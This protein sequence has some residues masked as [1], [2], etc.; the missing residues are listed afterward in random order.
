M[1]HFKEIICPNCGHQFV[2][3][4]YAEKGS[5]F[6][7]YCRKGMD[8]ELLSTSCPNCK[9]EM[10]ILNDSHVGVDIRSESIDVAGTVRGL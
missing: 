1:Y 10:V 7:V 5:S 3:L 9:I 4:E 8:E 6:I 2:W